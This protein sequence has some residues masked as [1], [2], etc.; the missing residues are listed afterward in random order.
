MYEHS[1]RDKRNEVRRH[2]GITRRAAF[3]GIGSESQLGQ[4]HLFLADA[5]LLSTLAQQQATRL[6]AH[7]QRHRVT[8]T[9]RPG[10]HPQPRS[11]R[12]TAHQPNAHRPQRTPQRVVSLARVLQ[13][14][15]DHH[16]IDQAARGCGSGSDP[17]S[18]P[19][20]MALR[21][22]KFRHQAPQLHV[23]VPGTTV[24]TITVRQFGCWVRMHASDTHAPSKALCQ[25]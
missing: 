11:H 10:P 7:Q 19:A 16:P 21:P 18:A 5:V 8:C 1:L 6:P 20:R 9:P 2:V 3:P 4:A 25:R 13:A 14:L 15:V 17:G 23:H 12:S 22:S 24:R